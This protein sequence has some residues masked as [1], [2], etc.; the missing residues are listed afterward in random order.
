ME[1]YK[2]KGVSIVVPVYN[3]EEGC[4][5]VLSELIKIM[6]K[7]GFEYE[8]VAINDGSSDG[9]A[10]ELDKLKDKIKI[11]HH[12]YNRG[13]GA[14]IKTGVKNSKYELIA[15]TDADGTYPNYKIPELISLMDRFDMVVG[16]R[17]GKDAKIPFIRRP[18][19]Y[20][21]TALANYLTQTKIPDLNSGLRIMKKELILRF[22]KILPDGFSFTTTITL[23][24]LT[25]GYSIEYVPISY[26]RRKGKSKINP[27]KDT[28]NF[29]Q[30]I[31]RTVL[32]FEPLRIFIPISLLLLLS[33]FLVLF[34]SWLNGKVMDVTTVILFVASIQMLGIGMLADIL[35]RRLL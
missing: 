33:S 9:S 12:P 35:D 16:A 21:I 34:I 3:E 15:I 31:I 20:F 13:Y 8:I 30:L 24:A 28:L 29:I 26:E 22:L 4:Y 27:I 1:E 6:E 11:V 7:S 14:A 2:K 19:K 17:V 23:A 5:E 10:K 25:N 18:A 32:Y